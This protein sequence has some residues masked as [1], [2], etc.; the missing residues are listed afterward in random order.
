MPATDIFHPVENRPLSLQDYKRLQMFPD[1]WQLGGKLADQYRQ[2][3]NAVP[4][5]LGEAVGRTI[6]AHMEGQDHRPPDGFQLS[7]YKG[8]DEVS[9]EAATRINL[10]L[11]QNEPKLAKAKPVVRAKKAITFEA[12]AQ[13]M[14]LFEEAGA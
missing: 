7:R 6:L 4:G 13:Q 1:N 8:T 9:W 3:G 10:G 11:D 14:Q 12:A 2:V 5:G